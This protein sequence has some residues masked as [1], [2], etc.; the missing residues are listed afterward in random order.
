MTIS[1]CKQFYFV[2][3]IGKHQTLLNRLMCKQEVNTVF[4]IFF[5]VI[6]NPEQTVVEKYNV[7][8]SRVRFN[9]LY[10]AHSLHSKINS[11]ILRYRYVI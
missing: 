5:F 11:I 9:N 3:I 7:K 10:M 8:C 6:S 1:L 4:G 2:D